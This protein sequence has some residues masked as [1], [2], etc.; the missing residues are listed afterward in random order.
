MSFLSLLFQKCKVAKMKREIGESQ[1]P[2]PSNPWKEVQKDERYILWPKFRGFEH[3]QFLNIFLSVLSRCHG[4]PKL[5]LTFNQSYSKSFDS[6]LERILQIAYEQISAGAPK[7]S[8]PDLIQVQGTQLSSESGQ[9]LWIVL[10]QMLC[11]VVAHV[12]ASE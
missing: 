9:Q 8:L 5:Y 6:W 7:T 2:E 10:T 4:H 12:R 3:F 11:T 1:L